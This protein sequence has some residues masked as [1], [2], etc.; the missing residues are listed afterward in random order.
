MSKIRFTRV[1]RNTS[2][3]I[4]AGIAGYASYWHQVHVAILA[5]ERIELAHV[6]PGSVDGL[7]VVASIC[8]VDARA[9]GRKPSWKVVAGFAL[10]IAASVGAN[11]MSALPTT[12]GRVVAAWP[13][14]ALLVVVEML[15]SKGR[16]IR[17]DEAAT[18]VEAP[19]KTEVSTAVALPKGGRPRIPTVVSADG[20]QVA[21]AD[22]GRVS[23]RT[24]GRRRSELSARQ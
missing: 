10:G 19:A 4:V 2:A 13:A 1:T 3:G 22:G 20:R 15:A 18:T 23:D 16:R 8:M 17:E 9:E 5:G 24:A 21:R 11:I 7:L 12:L 6:L 14:V